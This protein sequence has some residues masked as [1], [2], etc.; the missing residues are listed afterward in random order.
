MREKTD[1]RFDKYILKE[2]MYVK[3]GAYI[4][5]FFLRIKLLFCNLLTNKKK[6]IIDKNYQII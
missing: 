1:N 5:S 4:T 3:S 2:V 6:K